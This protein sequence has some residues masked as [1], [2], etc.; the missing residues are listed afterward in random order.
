MKHALLPLALAFL[1]ACISR[2]PVVP[3][4][5]FRPALKE[6]RVEQIAG[7]RPLRLDRVVQPTEIGVE[8][9]WRVSATELVPDETNL[10]AR[11]PDELLDGRLRDLLYGAGGFRPAFGA[12][13]PTLRVGIAR[14]EGDLH[15]KQAASLELIATLTEG[16]RRESR[17]RIH[18]E[19]ELAERSAEAL[20][21]AMGAALES[22]AERVEA[23]VVERL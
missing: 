22:A 3:V 20:A 2:A 13:D 1:P 7:T 14:Y 8:M 5:Y 23:W 21:V 12:S 19:V 4:Q 17:T 15:G 11:R 16:D 9:L 10:W 6:P 18:V